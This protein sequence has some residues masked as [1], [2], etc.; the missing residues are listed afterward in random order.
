MY[1]R[2]YKDYAIVTIVMFP[3]GVNEVGEFASVFPTVEFAWHLLP[4]GMDNEEE[5]EDEVGYLR[6]VP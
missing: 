1:V 3:G 6:R 4:E 5:P 2:V